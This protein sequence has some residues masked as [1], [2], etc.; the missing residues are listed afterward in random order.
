MENKVYK[1]THTHVVKDV[2]VSGMYVAVAIANGFYPEHLG[3]DFVT[4]Y[5]SLQTERAQYPKGSVMNAVLKLAGNGVYGNSNNTYSPFYDPKYTYTVT[6]NGQL[7]LLML[8][9]MLSLCPDIEMIQANTDGITALV[10][11]E[12]EGF[13]NAWCLA[14]ECTTGLKLEHK[15]YTSMHIRDVNNYIA[16]DTKGNVKRKGAYFYPANEQEFEGVWNKDFSNTMAPKGAE[17][18]MLHGWTPEAAVKLH[19][20]PFDFMCRYKTTAG[21]KVYIGDKEMPKTLRYYVST[22]GERGKKIATPKGEIGAFKRKNKLKDDF[23]DKV[24]AEIGPGVWDSRIHTGNKSKYTLTTTNIES[25]RLIKDCNKA[26]EF[27]W[28]DVDID[29]YVKEIE[30]LVISG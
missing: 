17:A 11:R 8:V 4:A 16:V 21:A 20:D 29:Y 23:F 30:K 25:G 1:S 3:Q 6:A 22:A 7:Q 5:R 19:T 27:K 28:S 12:V 9:E 26:S 15:D 2:D 18:V 14:W 13:F 24:M 10:P